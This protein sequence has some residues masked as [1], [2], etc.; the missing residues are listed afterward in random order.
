MGPVAAV[1]GVLIVGLVFVDSFW[2]VMWSGNGGGPLT[3]LLTASIRTALEAFPHGG[4]RRRSLLGP[5][6][7]LVIVLMWAA[8]LLV[9]FSLIVQAM[10]G[11]IVT[12]ATARPADAWERVYFVGYTLFTLGMG[13]FVPS[14]N[15]ARLLT[16]AMNALGMFMVTLGVTY[17][18]PVISASVS[19]RSFAS[20]VLSLGETP[21]EVIVESWDGHRICLDDELRGMATELSALSHQH[22]AYPVLHLFHS[23]DTSASA[24]RA[25]AVVEG[26]LGLLEAVD[27]TV[28]PSAPVRRQL[29]ASVDRYIDTFGSHVRG[30]SEA[31]PPPGL[32]PLTRAGIPLARDQEQL[33][34]LLAASEDRRRRLHG[35][36]DAAGVEAPTRS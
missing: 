31:P 11:G 27:P 30:A 26:V 3:T 14:G 16:V 1:A 8:L 21:A 9:G 28:A 35:V 22:L 23:Q 4:R 34:L 29:R 2:T 25:V 7:L 32:E 33:D 13:D 12:S 6:V 19:A 10:P 18:L 17:L 15:G 5:L 24:P 20:S 36:L